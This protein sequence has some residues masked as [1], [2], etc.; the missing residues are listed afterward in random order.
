M[1]RYETVEQTD[2][3]GNNSHEEAQVCDVQVDTEEVHTSN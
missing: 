2:N 3:E 1:F